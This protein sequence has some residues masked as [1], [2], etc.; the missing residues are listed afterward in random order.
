MACEFKR[1]V[2]LKATR[3]KHRCRLGQNP[4]VI[5][6]VV[7][8]RK[9]WLPAETNRELQGDEESPAPVQ[10]NSSVG[11]PLPNFKKT[12]PLGSIRSVRRQADK[13]FGHLFCR[14]C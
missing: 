3:S 4:A 8:I 7:E 1:Q 10:A 12:A 6:A 2:F 13:K 11:L 5:R 9:G 14:I